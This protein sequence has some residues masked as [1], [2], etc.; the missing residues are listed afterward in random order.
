MKN[1]SNKGMFLE[2]V[3]ERTA[4][5]FK[6]NKI[7]WICKRDV[8]MKIYRINKSD[9]SAKL[10]SK[11]LTD[12]YGLFNGYYFDFEAKQTEEEKF[13]LSNLKEH[14]Y[15]H[16]LDILDFH[17]ISFLIVYFVM[18]DEYYIINSSV[19]KKFFE[20]NIKTITIEQVR[21]IGYKVEFI[22][23]GI[24]EIDKYLNIVIK[25]YKDE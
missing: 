22:F 14:Q 23:P 11:G 10:Q 19:L 5:H 3:I 17:G 13:K 4:N 18:Y 15:N 6:K 25:E 7:C 2:S 21:Q 1:Y 8:P 16:L 12:Y 24:L 20:N 9:V